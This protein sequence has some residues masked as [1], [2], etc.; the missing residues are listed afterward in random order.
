MFSLI[1]G[2]LTLFATSEAYDAPVCNGF[3]LEEID[4]ASWDCKPDPIVY[5]SMCILDCTDPYAIPE[6]DYEVTCTPEGWIPN[7]SEVCIER[8]TS[9]H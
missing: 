8:V 6:G 2:I 9:Y 4:G 7:P 1:V 5:G 3:L